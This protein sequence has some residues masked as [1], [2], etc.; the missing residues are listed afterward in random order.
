MKYN[1]ISKYEIVD[2]F[3]ITDQ[4]EI[5]IGM[6][7][8]ENG[9]PVVINHIKNLKFV[10]VLK[11]E[12]LSDILTNLVDS[13]VMEDEVVFITKVIEADPLLIYLEENYIPIEGR[14]SLAF[15]YL[16][17]ITKYD[18]LEAIS[19]NIL[20]D[21]TQLV[22]KDGK[23]VF[24]ELYLI[25]EASE[26]IDINYL[27]NKISIVLEKLIY[28]EYRNLKRE[29]IL[30]Q[31]VH[32]FIFDLKNNTKFN[33]FKDIMEEF[34][35][36][37]IYHLCVE[38]IEPRTRA[39]RKN[40]GIISWMKKASLDAEEK[41]KE[42]DYK[43]GFKEDHTEDLQLEEQDLALEEVSRS[44]NKRFSKVIPIVASIVLLMG[45]GIYALLNN[46]S[47]GTFFNLNAGEENQQLS[48][49]MPIA[50]FTVV[51]KEDRWKFTNESQAKG[52]GN[53]LEEYHW[54][55]AKKDKVITSAA[56][57]NLT[58]AFHEGGEYT[59]SLKVRDRL[60]QWSEE[61]RKVI[62]VDLAKVDEGQEELHVGSIEDEKK[63]S[64]TLG[65]GVSDD[66]T[67]TKD[68]DA[69]WK[70]EAIEG[71]SPYV[72]VDLHDE[73]IYDTLSFWVK[74]NTVNQIEFNIK[75]YNQDGNLKYLNKASHTIKIPDRWELIN[76]QLSNEA[77]KKVVMEF[78]SFQRPFW[79]ADLEFNTYK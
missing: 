64:V 54:E 72:S 63:Y 75:G 67:N 24:D 29:E 40:K 34:R 11:R 17:E 22:V 38:S 36:L 7:L 44:E 61:Y 12:Q 49:L 31:E 68:T 20:I 35:K 66:D 45:V 26:D 25:N 32:Q 76:L 50:Y 65:D 48:E 77:L 33:S 13:E 5:Y 27:C 55:I 78:T 39:S 16:Q 8:S 62:T 1:Y 46:A 37:Y 19:K 58:L 30:L 9:N 47:L 53:S 69:S 60:D 56:T 21:E 73:S 3:K 57:K 52:E 15:S 41:N 18:P 10:D 51:E 4:Q 71:E 70:I 6:E 42:E 59:I 14:M 23:I 2:T 28:F 43:E 74:S 79:V